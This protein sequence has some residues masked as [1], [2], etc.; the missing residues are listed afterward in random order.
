MSIPGVEMEMWN[1]VFSVQD[2]VRNGKVVS[3]PKLDV[4]EI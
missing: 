2:S 4:K 3:I 1:A